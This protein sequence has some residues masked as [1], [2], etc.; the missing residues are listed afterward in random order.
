MSDFKEEMKFQPPL[1]IEQILEEVAY[2]I[3]TNSALKALELL[4]KQ[5]G[6]EWVK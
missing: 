6:R 4:A 5:N 1:L 2:L 3:K